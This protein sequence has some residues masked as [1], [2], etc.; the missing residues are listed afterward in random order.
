MHSARFKPRPATV[1]EGLEFWVK[2]IVN[3]Y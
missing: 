2:H 1:N 3:Y